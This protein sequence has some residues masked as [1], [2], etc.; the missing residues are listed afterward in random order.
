[1]RKFALCLFLALLLSLATLTVVVRAAEEEDDDYLDKIDFS[2][3]VLDCDG[4]EDD[5]DE[6]IYNVIY[7]DVLDKVG[8]E[9]ILVM[10]F[11]QTW[12]PV[13]QA[14]KPIYEQAAKYFAVST[15]DTPRVH[16]GRATCGAENKNL[17]WAFNVTKLPTIYIGRK[18]QFKFAL[19]M[20]DDTMFPQK[21]KMKRN[22]RGPYEGLGFLDD[23]NARCLVDY[24]TETF[25]NEKY[26]KRVGLDPSKLEVNGPQEDISEAHIP[27][28]CISPEL[29]EQRAKEKERT[30][31]NKANAR[32]WKKQKK[33]TWH[34]KLRK[35]LQIKLNK[36]LK[37]YGWDYRIDW[38]EEAGLKGPDKLEAMMGEAMAQGLMG[39]NKEVREQRVEL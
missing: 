20:Y 28:V 14:F 36:K 11:Y 18:E 29:K 1:M 21:S 13:C 4:E 26:M 27:D 25:Q 3:S 17:C 37:K 2:D 6:P 39:K 24:V 10:E 30:K 38:V 32:R 7:E 9:D 22:P 19:N 33:N 31:R 34:Y 15:K 8:D 35:K 23:A 12:C 5:D 16:L